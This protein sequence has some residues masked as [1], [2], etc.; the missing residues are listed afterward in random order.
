MSAIN[1][2]QKFELIDEYWS[3]KIVAELNG[4]YVKLAKFKGEFVWHSH[5]HEDEY[6][7]VFKGQIE[8]HLRDQIVTVPQGGCYVVPKG[9]EHKPVA[10]GEAH[11]LMFE[12]M[13]TEQSGDTEYHG[14]V[15]IEDQNWI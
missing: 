9:V 10:H 13:S 8:I 14:K 12:P 3:P 15:E 7:Q 5:E 6:F 11:V 2:E 1:F 4:Q